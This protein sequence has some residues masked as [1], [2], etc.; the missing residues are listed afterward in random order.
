MI[1]GYAEWESSQSDILER[2]NN[3][4]RISELAIEYGTSPVIMRFHIDKLVNREKLL[5]ENELYRSMWESEIQVTAKSAMRIVNCFKRWANVTTIEGV[6][7]MSRQEI[8]NLRNFGHGLMEVVE[9]LGWIEKS[10]KKEK[11]VQ[12]SKS[13]AIVYR[14]LKSKGATEED[15]KLYSNLLEKY[16]INRF[17]SSLLVEEKEDEY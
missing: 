8:L 16:Q 3:G 5:E 2:F 9:D 6:Q 1:V 7:K 11:Y 12:H 13:S 10:E 4:A 17:G 14:L 15:L